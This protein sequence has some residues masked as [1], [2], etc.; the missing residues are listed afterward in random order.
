MVHRNEQDRQLEAAYVAATKAVNL[1]RNLRRSNDGATEAHF[2]HHDPEHKRL[3]AVRD[4]ALAS[5][6]GY[7][8]SLGER[9]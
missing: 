7:R 6:K 4:R 5:L 1:Y 3:L 8:R 9:V 2:D